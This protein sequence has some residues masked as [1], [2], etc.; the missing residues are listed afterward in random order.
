ML[1]LVPPASKEQKWIV[2]LGW[3]PHYMNQIIDM[4]YFTGSTA[5]TFG[6]KI[7]SS[8]HFS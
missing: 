7:C 1:S 5:D 2:F 4:N 8:P 6:E 3:S